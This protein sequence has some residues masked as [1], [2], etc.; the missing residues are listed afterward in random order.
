VVEEG[1]VLAVDDVEVL[2]C[3]AVAIH[4]AVSSS[5]IE[6]ILRARLQA[7]SDMDV[8]WMQPEAG[9]GGGNSDKG[10]RLGCLRK[11]KRF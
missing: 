6:Q 2:V 9:G 7:N 8:A 11:A 10:G 4:T 5:N 1:N 3:A